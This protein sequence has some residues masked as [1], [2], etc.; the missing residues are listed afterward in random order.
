MLLSSSNPVFN[1]SLFSSTPH[2]I[3]SSITYLFLSF[4]I[5]TPITFLSFTRYII[6]RC[7]KKQT[8]FSPRP[9][10]TPSCVVEIPETEMVPGTSSDYVDGESKALKVRPCVVSTPEMIENEPTSRCVFRSRCCNWIVEFWNF[11]F[12]IYTNI[13]LAILLD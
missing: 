13:W 3:L 7:S 9:D 12:Y 10:P 2:S 8:E 6:P 4:S 5:F 1:S 11:C